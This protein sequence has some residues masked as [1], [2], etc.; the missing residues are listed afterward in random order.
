MSAEKK[1]VNLTVDGK[2]VSVEQGATVLDA[3]RKAGVYIPTLCDHEGL[4]PYGGCRLCIVE[5][6]GKPGTPASCSTPVAEGMTVRTDSPKV[7]DLRRGVLELMLSEHPNVCLVCSD[8]AICFDA[9]ECTRKAEITTGCKTCPKTGRCELQNVVHHLY[10]DKGP[11]LTLPSKYKSVPVERQ[12]PFFDRDD[13]LCILCGR[14]VRACGDVQLNYVLDFSFRGSKARI[15]TPFG[16]AQ[17]DSGCRFCGACVDACPT[18]ALSD[19]V[20][21][22][23]GK[24]DSQAATTCPYCSTGC[25]LDLGIKSGRVVESTPRKDAPNSGDACVRGRFSVVEFVR[26]VRRLKFPLVRRGG[27]LMEVEWET[28]LKAAAH[29]ILHSKP[30]KAALLASGSL[31]NEDLFAA[32]RFAKEVLKTGNMDSSLRLSYG[33]LL[34]GSCGPQA[35]I[36][37]LESA[38]A[39]LVAGGDP[40]F[41]HPVLALKL[42]RAAKAGRTRLVLVNPHATGL[43]EWAEADI[44][45]A[46]GDERQAL[47]KAAQS[48]KG[49]KSTVIVFGTGLMRRLDGGA[50]RDAVAALAKTLSAKVMP[51][52]SRAN[53]RGAKELSSFFGSAGLRA[54]EILQAGR[55]GQLDLLYLAGEDMW[56]GAK[57]PRFVI[58]QDMFL[59][60]EAGKIADV[61]FPVCSFV[62]TEGTFVSLEGRFG[63]SR[64]A[65]KPLGLSKA[66]WEIFGLLAK[67]VGAKG[68][69]WMK[70]A[71]VLADL[72]KTVPFYK[73]VSFEAVEKGGFFGKTSEAKRREEKAGR[74]VLGM[75]PER[76]DREYPFALVAEYDEYAHRSTP[77]GAEVPGIRHLQEIAFVVLS[78][79]DAQALGVKDGVPVR[80]VSR[81]G[82]L[83]AR[84]SVRAGARPGVA[85]VLARSGEASPAKVLDGILDPASKTPDETCAVRIEK[86]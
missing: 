27:E 48:L 41:S 38:S 60:S 1:T 15:D 79:S 72:A 62:E 19:R 80:V 78:Q 9:M 7:Q 3:A 55:T 33:P 8:K 76:P 44:R 28:A 31:T 21:R 4:A 47:E 40:D 70:P 85:R 82:A 29:G 34:D 24:I 77:L 35:S 56:A 17:K 16:R 30:E 20:R 11:T 73:G 83:S 37:D 69:E 68:L 59:P 23:E 67:K 18:G 26:S 74:R 14:C 25:R 63:R 64:Q 22:W 71:E 65:V 66:D 49:S 13:N 2:R 75:V 86:V 84:A 46:P 5:I 42:K 50:N 54:S 10:G 81:R 32:H 39:V 61:V 58:V 53:D 6:E 43:S 45:H 36:E 52:Y 57:R 51:L 12:D